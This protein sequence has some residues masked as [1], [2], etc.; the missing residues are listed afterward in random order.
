MGIS[1]L[2]SALMMDEGRLSDS[3]PVSEEACDAAEEAYDCPE[4]DEAC[5]ASI[6][7]GISEESAKDAECQS[8]IA[9]LGGSLFVCSH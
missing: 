7:S 1:N 2:L 3:L 6:N 5:I 9:A 4:F 8:G